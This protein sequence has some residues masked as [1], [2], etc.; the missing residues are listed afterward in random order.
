[1]MGFKTSHKLYCSKKT[2]ER[3]Q[4]KVV[5]GVN[6]KICVGTILSVLKMN[7]KIS[8]RLSTFAQMFT[9]ILYCLNIAKCPWLV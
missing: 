6:V 1:M 2:I 3:N 5:N 9:C 7:F 4:E 8:L